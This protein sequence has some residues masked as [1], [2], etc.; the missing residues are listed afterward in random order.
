VL[1]RRPGRRRSGDQGSLA[2]PRNGDAVLSTATVTNAQPGDDLDD[3]FPG[4]GAVS[5]AWDAYQVQS[6]IADL[7]VRS[8]HTERIARDLRRSGAPDLWTAE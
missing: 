1:R 2:T 8:P 4:S 6:S 3:L 5:R 7:P